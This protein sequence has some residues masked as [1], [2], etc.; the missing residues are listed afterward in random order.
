MSF[1][2]F[3]LSQQSLK[4]PCE[5]DTPHAKTILTY[6]A[7][8]NC[9]NTGVQILSLCSTDELPMCRLHFLCALVCGNCSA[10]ANQPLCCVLLGNQD[11]TNAVRNQKGVWEKPLALFHGVPHHCSATC[12]KITALSAESNKDTVVVTLLGIV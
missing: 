6:H 12:H 9:T 3:P 10:A 1:G 7:R 4:F 8:T 2:A 5:N 11:P